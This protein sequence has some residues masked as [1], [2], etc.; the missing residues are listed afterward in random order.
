MKYLKTP[1][2]F[3]RHLPTLPII[4]LAVFPMMMMDVW[5]EIYHRFCFPFYNIP[6]LKRKH[7][8][9]ID[10]HKLS[11]LNFLQK[12]NCVYCG[13]ANGIVNYW[14]AI[15]AETEKYWCGIQHKENGTYTPPLH[16]EEL[17]EF[18][19]EKAYKEVYSK[20]KTKMF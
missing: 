4:Y 5:V 6:Y 20:S 18:G 11:Y 17:I 8:I 7:Y 10:R 1:H 3:L 12:L 14:S 9:R 2:R 13:Y 16:H 19:D 15:F